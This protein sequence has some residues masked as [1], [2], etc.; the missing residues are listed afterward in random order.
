MS[1]AKGPRVL[2]FDIE[3]SPNLGYVWGK[4]EQNVLSFKKEWELLSFAWKW[5]GEKEVYCLGRDDFYRKDE[6]GLVQSLWNILDLADVVV[7]HNGD[8]FDNKKARA[9]FVEHGLKPPKPYKTI[10]TKKIA[11]SNFEFNSNSLNDLGQTLK[12]GK[13][14]PTGGFDLWLDCMAGKPSAWKKM[15]AY[16]KQD[17]ILLEKVYDRLKIWDSRHINLAAMAERPTCC[18]ICS[19]KELQCRGY[20]YTRASKTQRIMCKSCGHWSTGKRSPLK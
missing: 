20:N 16:N 19:S 15:K 7:A 8:A 1:K 6:K 11:K 12:L 10:D 2:F 13:K 14:L 17:V 18:P 4:W 9:K 3:T 5:Q